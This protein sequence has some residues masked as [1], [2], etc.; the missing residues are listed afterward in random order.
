M[1][2][3]G[4]VIL[5][6]A[7]LLVLAEPSLAAAGASAANNPFVEI[8]KNIKDTVVGGAQNLYIVG[9]ILG[10]LVVVLILKSVSKLIIFLVVMAILAPI[11]AASG[12]V[13]N[14]L[15][16]GGGAIWPGGGTTGNGNGNSTGGAAG[17]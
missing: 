4:T 14:T 16:N 7:G 12:S 8:T 10:A 2:P 17:P 13:R 3:L 6:A 9:L 5:A 1:V 15:V 11:V